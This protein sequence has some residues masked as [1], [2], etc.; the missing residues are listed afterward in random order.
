[1]KS[2][3]LAIG[4]VSANE[5][6]RLTSMNTKSI[7]VDTPKTEQVLVNGPTVEPKSPG[8]KKPITQRLYNLFDNIFY[9]HFDAGT[10]EDGT[11]TCMKGIPDSGSF[12]SV[13]MTDQ[14][15]ADEKGN[16]DGNCDTLVTKCLHPNASTSFRLT[17]ETF[18]GVSYGQG[19]VITFRAHERMTI[20]N[21]LTCPEG[22]THEDFPILGVLKFDAGFNTL[23]SNDLCAIIGLGKIPETQSDKNQGSPGID[24]HAAQ[25]SHSHSDAKIEDLIED[26]GTTNSTGT[27]DQSMNKELDMDGLV[28][29]ALVSTSQSTSAL[30]ASNPYASLVH[31]MGFDTFAFCMQAA[32][33]GGAWVRW[34]HPAPSTSE[35]SST[36]LSAST[37]TAKTVPIIGVNH[38]AFEVHSIELVFTHEGDTAKLNDQNQSMADVF[39][40]TVDDFA[41]KDATTGDDQQ[42]KLV[43]NADGSLSDAPA[44]AAPAAASD[45]AGFTPDD[46]IQPVEGEGSMEDT[47]GATA[48]DDEVAASPMD[49]ATAKILGSASL[50]EN[51]KPK[52]NLA[53]KSKT[54]LAHKANKATHKKSPKA[55]LDDED[56]P[57]NKKITDLHKD[58]TKTVVVSEDPIVGK[59][60]GSYLGIVDTGTSLIGFPP[61]M[62]AQIKATIDHWLEVKDNWSKSCSEED[63]PKLRVNVLASMLEGGLPLYHQF[64]LPS[65]SYLA[66]QQVS[67]QS[68]MENDFLAKLFGA[69]PEQKKQSCPVTMSLM[70]MDTSTSKG[71]L[72]LFGLPWFRAF[73]VTFNAAKRQI[74]VQPNPGNGK[75]SL[76][77]IDPAAVAAANKMHKATGGTM[78]VLIM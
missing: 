71:P 52:T 23:V 12:R 61:S 47:S 73:M 53:H 56:T 68:S 48:Q 7:S 69:A 57:I 5:H 38:W 24:K 35:P 54:H 18:E 30:P 74:H 14:C 39:S 13:L 25:H 75:C 50:A 26:D 36:E 64:E 33:G 49:A 43:V 55:H 2:A 21:S 76:D 78:Q 67:Q 15:I 29:S 63:F 9:M 19:S 41:K 31:R 8:C 46:N 11:S 16:R 6:V 32:P 40:M 77:D 37:D 42:Q 3:F 51:K 22:L 34:G 59:N 70:A 65:S 66:K 4:A 44:A 10:K 20:G 72:V 58:G 60:A 1:M 45:D 27:D 62:V 17:N 28:G